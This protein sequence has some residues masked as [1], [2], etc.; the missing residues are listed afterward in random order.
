M[1]IKLEIE[2]ELPDECKEWSDGE[3]SQYV[4]DGYTHYV[5]CQHS[6]DVVNWCVAK[7]RGEPTGT[8]IFH[9]H[10]LWRDIA[11]AAKYKIIVL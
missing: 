6:I 2:L 7:Q 3:L 11:R 1:K 9:Y 10:E 5:T 8:Q 4:F